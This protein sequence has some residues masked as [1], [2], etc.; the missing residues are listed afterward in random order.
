MNANN[1]GLDMNSLAAVAS[2]IE[3]SAAADAA[4]GSF[5]LVYNLTLDSVAGEQGLPGSLGAPIKEFCWRCERT[6][7][8]GV[9][10]LQV[11]LGAAVEAPAV[12]RQTGQLRRARVYPRLD[13]ALAQT[14]LNGVASDINRLEKD[15]Q[16]LQG[17]AVRLVAA[18]YR[19][20]AETDL[21]TY[22]ANETRQS[23]LK[24][25]MTALLESARTPQARQETALGLINQL[26]ADGD[27]EGL[28][29]LL[30]KRMELVRQRLGLDFDALCRQVFRARLDKVGGDVYA[31]AAPRYAR[32]LV[33]QWDG[34][35]SLGA[36]AMRA[37]ERLRQAHAYTRNRAGR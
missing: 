33:S 5:A 34:N 21:P 28:S 37:A 15:A 26:V 2:D 24:N 6:A 22:G 35:T 9:K 29:V 32:F 30:G 13:S 20:S 27:D 18:V 25:D 36:V 7:N 10:S 12:D 8:N 23:E 19:A 14:A 16:D 17:E 1:T 11:A 4:A 3:A 31:L